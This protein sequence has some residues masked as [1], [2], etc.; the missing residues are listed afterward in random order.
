MTG[1]AVSAGMKTRILQLEKLTA[2]IN[3]M[4]ILIR[5]R[6]MRVSE[7]INELSSQEVF[8]NFLF[9]NILDECMNDGSLNV[10]ECWHIAANKTVFL[11]DSDKRILYNIGEQLGSTDI[12]GQLSMLAMNKALAQRNLL[13]AEEEF[14]IKGKMFRNVWGLCGIAAGIMLI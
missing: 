5:F 4:E 1:T 9:L 13:E 10:N 8:R 14:R 2:M 12:D 7:L 6:A 3:E 11:S